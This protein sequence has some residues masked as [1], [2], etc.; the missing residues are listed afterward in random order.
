MNI[1]PL[2]NTVSGTTTGQMLYW[3]GSKWTYATNL[4]WTAASST[5][6]CSNLLV[7]ATSSGHI[8]PLA[9]ATYDLGTATAP[10]K[11]WRAIYTGSLSTSFNSFSDNHI[12][13][14]NPL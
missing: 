12:R 7:S 9:D 13:W 8:L 11:K 14:I 5:L 1:Y 2:P 3:D 10:A 6:S 4:G